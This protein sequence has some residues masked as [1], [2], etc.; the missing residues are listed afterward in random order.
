MAL[1]NGFTYRTSLRCCSRCR[2]GVSCR[3]IHGHLGLRF[4][5]SP[6]A[7]CAFGTMTAVPPFI[8]AHPGISSPWSTWRTVSPLSFLEKAL[9]QRNTLPHK[10]GGHHPSLYSRLDRGER[11]HQPRGYPAGGRAALIAFPANPSRKKPTFPQIGGVFP[12]MATAALFSR[13]TSPPMMCGYQTTPTTGRR[14]Y[15]QPMMDMMET[16]SSAGGVGRPRCE[17]PF[18]VE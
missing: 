15:F 16:A 5:L 10:G 6:Q 12:W 9:S 4:H 3:P 18:R 7:P 8:P 13:P 1:L 2:V 17:Q 14:G 11:N